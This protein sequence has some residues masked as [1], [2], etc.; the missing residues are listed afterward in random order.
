MYL[1][2]LIVIVDETETIT[3]Y[4]VFF[5]F[6]SNQLIISLG[7][8]VRFLLHYTVVKQVRSSF[9]YETITYLLICRL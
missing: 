9:V 5:F 2:S 8:S 4:C 3:C 1:F 7:F 6:Q